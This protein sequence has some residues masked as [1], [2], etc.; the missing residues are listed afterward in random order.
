MLAAFS[1]S[2]QFFRSGFTAQ[3][4]LTGHTLLGGREQFLP[5]LRS[6]HPLQVLVFL[7][8]FPASSLGGSQLD[9]LHPPTHHWPHHICL[10]WAGSSEAPE[11][12]KATGV[13]PNTFSTEAIAVVSG[14]GQD[15]GGNLPWRVQMVPQSRVY[16]YEVA[17]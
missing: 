13:P 8:T 11:I 10:Q 14:S 4:I 6:F 17:L 2:D 9:S 5:Q 12:W 1:P 15:G 16:C 7:P 3:H